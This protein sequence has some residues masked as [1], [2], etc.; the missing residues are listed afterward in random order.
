MT[1]LS[2]PLS[3]CPERIAMRSSNALSVSLTNFVSS[4]SIFLVSR[5]TPRAPK[6]STAP[7]LNL[8][9][10]VTPLYIP[11]TT[12]FAPKLATSNTF[13]RPYWNP[14]RIRAPTVMT[15]SSA[16]ETDIP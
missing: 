2:I 10:L 8:G 11:E 1:M 12:C 3:S 5:S 4:K 9:V 15:S 6:N 14:A 16:S 7:L 13:K